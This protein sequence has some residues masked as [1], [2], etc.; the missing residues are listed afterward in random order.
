MHTHFILGPAGSGKTF[1]CLA[2]IRA[3]LRADPDGPPLLL[4]A[5]RQSTFLLEKQL[6]ADGIEGF[7]RLHI[8]S[9]DRLA[10]EL[11]E[12][13]GQ[14]PAG[15]LSEEGRIMVLR[16][17]LL[18]HQAQLQAFASTSQSAGFPSALSQILR[19]LQR[20]NVPPLRLRTLAVPGGSPLLQGKLH[21]LALL[22]EAYRAWL[23]EHRLNDADELLLRAATVPS[24]SD[25]AT[26]T[27]ARFAGI[28]VDGFAEMTLAETGLL[29]AVLPRCA[30]ATLA[31]CLQNQAPPPANAPTMWSVN[32]DSFQRCRAL[33]QQLGG[34]AEVTV[35]GERDPLPRFAH[36]PAI[37]SLAL[38]WSEAVYQP[39]ESSAGLNFVEC[40]D[41]E[42]EACL[43]ARLVSEHVRQ[44]GRYREIS[45]IVRQLDEYAP[46]LQRVFQRHELPFFAD[47]REPM[48]HHPLAELTRSA[49]RVAALNARHED[50]LNALKTGL[51]VPHPHLVDNLE[52]AALARGVRGREWLSLDEYAA[53]VHLTQPASALLAQPIAAFQGFLSA[54][55]PSCDG[56]ALAR[57]LRQLWDDLSVAGTLENWQAE[58]DGLGLPPKY[59]AIHRTALE[60]MEQWCGNLEMAFAGTALAPE[61]WLPIIE[62][63]LTGMSLGLIPP[64]LDQVFIGAIDRSRQPEVKLTIILGMNAGVF[65]A[66]APAP[67][68]LNRG[69]RLL[70]ESEKEM[71][72]G[73][74]PATLAARENYYAYIACTR[75]SQHLCVAW[76]RRGVDGKSR[77]P[78]PIAER[79]LALTGLPAHAMPAEGEVGAFDG[80][81]KAFSGSLP[82]AQAASLTELQQCAGWDACELPASQSADGIGLANRAAA[83]LREQLLPPEG[84]SARTLGPQSLK[85]LYPERMVSSSVSGLETFA[86]CPFRHF[87][88]QQ[89]R[90]AERDEFQA[91]SASLGNL[92]HAILKQFHEHTRQEL[93]QHW[94]AWTPAA[95]AQ[96][97]QELGKQLAESADFAAQR[98]D[99]IIRWETD[100][101]IEK[102]AAAVAQM[103]GWF[104]TYRFDPVLAELKFR[105]T[106]DADGNLPDVPA[107]R[108]PL[109]DGAVLRLQG[110]IDRVDLCADEAGGVRLAVM[111]YKT[112][113]KAP[114]KAQLQK[115]YELQL[116]A[117]LSLA[118]EMPE[119]R[120]KLDRDL[121]AQCQGQPLAA[122]GA[123]YVPIQTKGRTIKPGT[124]AATSQLQRLESLTH[125]GRAN[126]ESLS[127]FDSSAQP[128]GRSWIHSL[129]FKPNPQSSNFLEP[130]AF[131]QLCQS[132]RGQ[133]V[134][135][136][137]AILAGR[138]GVLP[139]R[140]SAQVIACD[141]C[142]YQPLCRFEPVFGTFRP[143]TY[144][145]PAKGGDKK[146]KPSTK[147]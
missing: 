11:L 15:F 4:V 43:A 50:W 101:A 127:C 108:I 45:I 72:L 60:Q 54:V 98:Q 52:N 25:S 117:Y 20:A 110:S 19:E 66:P 91:D 147:A 53:A 21:D 26:G 104:Q 51:V 144:D 61:A 63:G 46:V 132:V 89:L 49:L 48:S 120:A 82:A 126:K 10:R 39:L 129:Q 32:A 59:R 44:G 22:L 103:I 94:R 123:F 27:A 138:I 14:P 40:T 85:R 3:A 135:H 69:D 88:S 109:K 119:I 131:S 36:A 102:L 34:T 23:E 133:L 130:E 81:L 84:E 55:A 93:Q 47:H 118:C 74:D 80:R 140:F 65:P 31:F 17:L 106:P 30:Q 5:P 70:L 62:S 112:G 128:Q 97:I 35:L 141:Y 114:N 111:D 37:E 8:C 7:T 142:P 124:D 134:T 38:G 145:K 139:A 115:G 86:K 12:A 75:P 24:A 79:L 41:P 99:A 68:V 77:L 90:L 143:V 96:K 105:D 42:A 67:P 71:G 73:W 29:K 28:W 92:L 78:S 87:A 95:A 64:A 121:P 16:A 9:F 56:P 1:R 107:W 13:A 33:V 58:A 125:Q 146:K 2:E 18:K 116:L 57:A 83:V 137:E 122:A 6:L 113:G 136:A 76:S 100:A